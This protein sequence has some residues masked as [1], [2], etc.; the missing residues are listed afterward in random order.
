MVRSMTEENAEGEPVRREFDVAV[1][2]AGE[3]RGLVLAVV[4][5]LQSHG[6]DVFYDEDFASDTWGED[7]IAFFEKVYAGRARFAMLFISKS[8]VDKNWPSFERETALAFAMDQVGTYV[9]P[10]K[11]DDSR[12]PGL[13]PTRGYLDMRRVGVDGVIDATLKKVGPKDAK[14]ATVVY[15]G[16]VPESAEDFELILGLRPPGWEYQ[17]FAGRLNTRIVESKPL[18]N[19]HQMGYAEPGDLEIGDADALAKIDHFV[20]RYR[21]LAAQVMTVITPDTQ[22]AAFGAPGQSGDVDRIYHLAD[23][24]VDLHDELLANARMLRSDRPADP[25][26]RD[27]FD[28]LAHYAD[29]PQEALRT[30]VAELTDGLQDLQTRLDDGA[31]IRLELP[32]DWKIADA[33][34]TQFDDA[35]ARYRARHP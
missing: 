24:I 6:L 26:L 4:R 7:L 22:E 34:I 20:A 3:D 28:A 30:M 15:H 8:Y 14:S 19:D 23:R 11:L 10:V 18:F 31:Q 12:A 25:D 9:L 2:F 35:V 33:A 32:L 13:A 1:S 21:F 17:L 29:Q 5:G 27:A 16:R